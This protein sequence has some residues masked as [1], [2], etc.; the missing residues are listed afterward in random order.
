M[1]DSRLLI[2]I[3]VL[4]FLRTLPRR[5]Q[6]FLL[7]RFREIAQF[8]G[9]FSDF[10]EY[11]ARGQRI[12]VHVSGRFAIKYWGDFADR[13]LRILDVEPADRMN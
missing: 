11:D 2:A 3:E 4:D 8:P 9:K 7:Q 5:D 12:D 1:K 13:H 10:A 6:K